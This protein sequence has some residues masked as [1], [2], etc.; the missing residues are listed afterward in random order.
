ML[1]REIDV[2][3]VLQEKS[4]VTPLSERDLAVLASVAT[5]L[6]QVFV[7]VLAVKPGTQKKG[8]GKKLILAVIDHRPL[9]KQIYLDTPGCE[10]NKNTQ[11]FYEHVGFKPVMK[12]FVKA[13]SAYEC[14]PKIVYIY[15]KP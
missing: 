6:D 14:E 3:K 13:E 11:G 15:Q 2:H 9:I 4:L 10:A 12:I 7:D 5:P 1:V 8:L